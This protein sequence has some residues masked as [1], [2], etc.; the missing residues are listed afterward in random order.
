MQLDAVEARL[1]RPAGAV[2]EP[3]DD[4]GGSRSC[5]IAWAGRPW[6]GSGLLV[7]LSAM[8]RRV[9]DAGDVALPAAVAELEE[10]RATVG[11]HPLPDLR[12]NGILSSSSMSA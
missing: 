7:E 1:P 10:E 9:L 6:T 12:Q 4:L 11:V 3:G 8:F 2:A 5:V